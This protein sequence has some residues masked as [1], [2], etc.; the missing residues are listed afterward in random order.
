[1]ESWWPVHRGPLYDEHRKSRAFT[2][3]QHMC[4]SGGLVLWKQVSSLVS[5]IAG[6]STA[7]RV[8]RG[9][10][11]QAGTPCM[12]CANLVNHMRNDRNTISIFPHTLLSIPTLRFNTSH[13][14]IQSQDN[15]DTPSRRRMAMRSGDGDREVKLVFGRP[16]IKEY[17]L[18]ILSGAQKEVG[19][20]E[21]PE[22]AIV[23]GTR[24]PRQVWCSPCHTAVLFGTAYLSVDFIYRA[25]ASLLEGTPSPRRASRALYTLLIRHHLTPTS[26]L[27]FGYFCWNVNVFVCPC[28]QLSARL[29]G[30]QQQSKAILLV[31]DKNMVQSLGKVSQR[32]HVGRKLVLEST[33][34]L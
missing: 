9:K 21:A 26:V 12:Y 2:V 10:T 23:R 5:L 15:S 6:W 33:T 8:W 25:S 31:A 17:L 18:D 34:L 3:H 11:C 19:D 28:M 16:D 1:M 7:R 20:A 24:N 13:C 29:N 22:K 32:A 30:H 27:R 14:K 4:Y